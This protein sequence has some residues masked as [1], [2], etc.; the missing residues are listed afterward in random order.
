MTQG[1][2][3][4]IRLIRWIAIFTTVVIAVG[5]PALYLYFG[6]LSIHGEIIGEAKF[7][8][9]QITRLINTNPE[10]W[11][12]ESGRIGEML[13]DGEGLKNENFHRVVRNDGKLIVQRPAI[14]P[15]Y[16]WPNARVWHELTDY[17]TPVGHLEIVHS[18]EP[19]YKQ[20]AVV[21][22][23]SLLSSIF[24]YWAFRMVPMR[25]LTR[26]WE[27]ITYLATHDSL[28]DLPNRALF[29]DRLGK[30]LR[31]GR[32]LPDAV[33][34]Y[35]F[36]LDFFKDI[37]DTLGHAA[38]D[39]LLYQAASRMKECLREG[40][41]LARLG[42]DEFAACQIGIAD[43]QMAAATAER[44]I[45]AFKKPFNLNGTE[46]FV[47]VSIG[48]AIC[49]KDCKV[50]PSLLLNSADLALY[51]SKQNGRNT[52]H[53]FEEEMNSD[54]RRRKSLE[55]G[56]RKALTNEDLRLEYQ[57]QVELST[58][59]ITGFEALARWQHPEMGEI[60]PSQF[61][62]IAETSGMMRPLTE[63][64]VHKACHDAVR[65]GDLKIAVNLAPSLF[66][67]TGLTRIIYSALE[68][69]GLPPERLELEITEDNLIGDTERTLTILRE[70]KEMGVQIAL[71]D[72]G[73]GFSSLGYLRQFP[74]DKIKIDRSFI[75]D[76]GNEDD[77]D[78]IVRAIISMGHALKMD[79]IA[80]GVETL[81]Q[82]N[83]L[84]AEGCEQVQGF[85]YGRPMPRRDIETLLT[86]LHTLRDDKDQPARN[87]G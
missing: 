22:A 63:W 47:G 68:E 36:D 60:P 2:G 55:A 5:P 81:E 45:A 24:V 44:L 56:L 80:E 23:F 69:S 29:I 9:R 62:P 86:A 31:A 7:K 67:Q 32:R 14:E 83:I 39:Q 25:M 18:L 76:I 59:K 65:W 43:P 17:G 10:Y 79:V 85:L 82:A 8:A 50:R 3:P 34:I 40:D 48:I 26:A 53:F 6:Y 61:I 74:F 77:A 35:A 19:L 4:F 30:V 1:D 49:T 66:Q 70:L 75:N 52:Y 64:I 28:T 11:Q 87:A 57:P 15:E 20:G 41:V 73:T 46:A 42:G 16:T 38:G 54:L 58:Q 84:M 13:E 51:K 72:F 71:D 21:A 33:T 12:F 27:R 37:N 78:A